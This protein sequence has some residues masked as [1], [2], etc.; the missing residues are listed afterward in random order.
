MA[1]D[2]EDYKNLIYKLAHKFN[3]STG[4]EFDELVGWGNLKFVE[5]QKNYD[6]TMASFGTYLHWQIQGLFLEISRK[7][8]KWI[9]QDDYEIQEPMNPEKYLFFKEI[10]SG[11]SN[12]A[13]EVCSIIFETP[14][15]LINMI[16]GLDQPRGVN[17]HQIQKYL[18]KQGW[19]YCRISGTFQEIADIF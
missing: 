12:D 6:P 10:I 9:I 3:S 16:M 11:L 18:R 19:S 13:K 15:D 7:Q 1:L 4:I 2:Y 17:R 14:M 5:C 8:N